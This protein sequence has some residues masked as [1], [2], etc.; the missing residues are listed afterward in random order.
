[1]GAT[2]FLLAPAMNAWTVQPRTDTL[3]TNPAFQRLCDAVRERTGK[4]E[5]IVFW[6]P[7]VL[8][9]ATDRRSS[10]Y[11]GDLDAYANS[12]P[13]GVARYLERVKPQFIILDGEKPESK[14]ELSTVIERTP[15]RFDTVYR[16]ERFRLM[17][18]T[19]GTINQVIS[20]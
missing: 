2:A 12:S 11:P 14:G 9:L 16:N 10:A 6:N 8:A 18:Y 17:R 1:L 19:N 13:D 3:Y 4:D 20:K 15:Q 7:R 5:L